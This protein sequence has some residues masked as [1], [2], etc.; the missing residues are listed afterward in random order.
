MTLNRTIPLILCMSLLLTGWLPA[1]VRLRDNLVSETTVECVVVR[2]D[3]A[4]LSKTENVS[5]SGAMGRASATGSSEGSQSGSYAGANAGVGVIFHGGAE[6]G[7][8]WST[9]AERMVMQEVS[10]SHSIT[11]EKSVT[12]PAPDPGQVHVFFVRRTIHFAAGSVTEGEKT[13]EFRVPVSCGVDAELVHSADVAD[14]VASDW[15]Q[16]PVERS[17]PPPNPSAGQRWPMILGGR[18]FMYFRW[19]PP[20]TFLM[21]SPEDGCGGPQTR[22]TLTRGF[23]MAET[24]TTQEQWRIIMG[25]SLEQ[26]KPVDP[27]AP[28][29]SSKSW[30]EGPDFPMYC[31]TALESDDFARRLGQRADLR[32]S[33]P[34]EAQWEYACR[35]GTKT[36]FSFGDS[37]SALGNHAWY[38]SNSGGQAKPVRGRRPNAWG[39]HDMHGNVWEW[40]MDWLGNYPGGS[41]TDPKG[42]DSGSLRVRRSGSWDDVPLDLQSASQKGMYPDARLNTLGFR[43]VIASP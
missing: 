14:F 5:I 18:E 41:V 1:Q 30:G 21:G 23:W 28:I 16:G 40:C 35:A 25:T 42:P 38:E 22:V 13:A 26:M 20:G 34:T 15:K 37:D 31:V 43:V 33:L 3:G 17:S 27:F 32:V 36:H 7:K 2:N 24:E 6:T 9:S 39:L 10:R 4:P 8:N 29:D 12:L 19:I 11:S